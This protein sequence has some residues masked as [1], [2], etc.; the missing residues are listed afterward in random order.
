MPTR[1]GQHGL[2]MPEI[3][4]SLVILLVLGA[5]LYPIFYPNRPDPS[6]V[7]CMNQIRQLATACQMYTQDNKGRYPGVNWIA[8]ISGYLGNNSRMFYC[9]KGSSTG[10]PTCVNYGY[11]GL[12]IQPDGS[13]VTEDAFKAPTLVGIICDTTP[14]TTYPTGGIIG[15]ALQPGVTAV[16]PAPRHQGGT[17]VGYADGHSKFMPGGYDPRNLNNVVSRAFIHASPLGYIANPAGGMNTFISTAGVSDIGEFGGEYCTE[18]LLVAATQVWR[19][20]VGAKWH[21]VGFHGQYCSRPQKNV[22]WGTG[23]GVQPPGQSIVLAHDVVVFITAVNTKI[24]TNYFLAQQTLGTDVMDYP[25]IRRLFTAGCSANV[26]QAYTYNNNSGTRRFVLQ[27]LAQDGKPWQISKKA[28]IVKNDLEM[29]DKVSNDAYGIGYCSNVFADIER[30]QVVGVQAPDGRR[31][32]FP[33]ADIKARWQMP[34]APSWPLLRTLY[35]VYGG[36]ASTPT[37]NGIVDIMLAPNSPGMQA[38]RG[39]PLFQASFF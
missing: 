14:S 25:G 26:F 7:T 11:S 9:S 13:G 2:T 29:V 4:V 38:L 10:F 36:K 21:S 5:I 32:F 12:L 35:A 16:V 33:Q 6:L 27:H 3:L 37:G 31:Y 23:D 18:P 8:E 39:G 28:I 20:C 30:V 1:A 15:G 17:G 24:P 34:T 19:Q 22:V